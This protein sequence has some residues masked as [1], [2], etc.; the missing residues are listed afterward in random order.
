M[1]PHLSVSKI[2][3]FLTIQ[4]PWVM[5]AAWGILPILPMEHF[6]GLESPFLNLFKKTPT[7]V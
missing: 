5:P 2:H 3:A 6:N 1:S 4:M 7:N